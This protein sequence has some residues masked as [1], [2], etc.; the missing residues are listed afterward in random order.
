MSDERKRRVRLAKAKAEQAIDRVIT[1]MISSDRDA[2]WHGVHPLGAF[3]DFQGQRPERSGFTGVDKVWE[4]TCFLRDWPEDYLK[5]RDLLCSLRG[6][7]QRAVLYDR[8]LR[9]YTRR[10]AVDPLVPGFQLQVRWTDEAIAQEIGITEAAFRQR[11]SRG[12]RNLIFKLDPSLLA[13]IKC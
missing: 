3:F 2:G 7:Q 9:G 4:K 1:M 5:A 10:Q 12:Y 8:L 13:P 11:V 6:S